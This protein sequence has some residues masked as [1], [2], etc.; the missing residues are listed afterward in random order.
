MEKNI[1][2]YVFVKEGLLDNE[3]CQYAIE[4]L[5]QIDAWESHEWGYDT[6]S[7]DIIK[8]NE[9]YGTK[10]FLSG[11]PDEPETISSSK[12]NSEM[13]DLREF[14]QQ[15]I[16]EVLW[17]YID[18]LKF[19][20]YKNAHAAGDIKFLKY[21]LN[22]AMRIHCDHVHSIFDGEKKGIPVL[23]AI[24]IFND[25]FEGG[26]LVLCED[27][28]INIKEGGLV[29]FPSIFLFPHEVKIITKGNRYSYTTWIW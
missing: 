22:Q 9:L 7:A 12:E 26:N 4:K 3:F 13:K 20:W 23:T 18:N 14:L 11:H 25:D 29:M 10:N 5:N 21:S 28:N 15:K 2:K 16:K 27:K 24:G 8:G 6:P 17:E 19:E 1:E